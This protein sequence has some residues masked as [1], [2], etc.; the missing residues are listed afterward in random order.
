MPGVEFKHRVRRAV[1]G[2][3][4]EIA[5]AMFAKDGFDHVRADE[6]AAA[7]GI[8]RATFFRYFDSKEDAALAPLDELGNR[9]D[10]ALADR[11]DGEDVW[12]ALRR[13][14][15]VLS[16]ATV[17]ERQMM[18]TRAQLTER[19][20]SLKAHQLEIHQRWLE[21]LS[22]TLA[23]RCSLTQIEL[24]TRVAAALAALDIAG[25][26]WVGDDG[27]RDLDLLIDAAFDALRRP[28][29][30]LRRALPTCEPGNEHG[31]SSVDA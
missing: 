20:P 13:A 11:P 15:D 25:R 8:S 19:T 4:A 3:V 24:R 14:F 5:L 21:L 30:P 22:R 23:K 2:E 27:G 10:A 29:P 1:R 16:A 6:I 17:Q 9:V 7:A 12:T 18:L 31:V 26:A 28:S